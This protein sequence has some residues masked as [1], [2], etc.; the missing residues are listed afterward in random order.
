[1]PALT[2]KCFSMK[3]I[4]FKNEIKIKAVKYVES[5]KFTVC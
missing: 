3:K 4:K 2:P 1:M 5:Y